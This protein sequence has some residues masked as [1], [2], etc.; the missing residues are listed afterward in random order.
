MVKIYKPDLIFKSHILLPM[1]EG[2][3]H[4]SFLQFQVVI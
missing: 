2:G 4:I 3:E 1:G